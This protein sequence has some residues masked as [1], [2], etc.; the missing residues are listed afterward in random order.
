MN[1]VIVGLMQQ[2]GAQMNQT[3]N[4]RP[5]SAPKGYYGYYITPSFDPGY[6]NIDSGRSD[7]NR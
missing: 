3:I 4:Y 7:Y 5:I 6:K 2:L 1:T